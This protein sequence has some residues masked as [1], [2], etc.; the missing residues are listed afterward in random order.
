MVGFDEGR[1]EEDRRAWWSAYLGGGVW[2]A[3]VLPPYDRPMSAWQ[4]G[5]THLAAP[6]AGDWT[7]RIVAVE[8]PEE[9]GMKS[10]EAVR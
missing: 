5:W 1:P 10:S 6:A 4:H 7:A 3:H 8:T 2:E 9:E